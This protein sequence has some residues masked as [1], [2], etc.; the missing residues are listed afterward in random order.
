MLQHT[1]PLEGRGRVG[2]LGRLSR[3]GGLSRLGRLGGLSGLGGLG[4][5]SG[6][7]GLWR[8]VDGMNGSGGALGNTFA[9]K[10][11]DIEIN[12][13]QIVFYRYSSEG[14]GLSTFATPYACR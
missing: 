12:V 1:E 13:C 2:R 9:A 7:G 8:E 5:L 10:F 3:L 4:G 6:L 14:A 11:A